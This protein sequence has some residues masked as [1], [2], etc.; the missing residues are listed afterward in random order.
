M[1]INLVV[2]FLLGGTGTSSI[3]TRE[4]R[5]PWTVQPRLVQPCTWPV[6]RRRSAY[7]ELR[8]IG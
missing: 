3:M 5:A 1:S 6:D 4:I 8:A 7:G 2:G